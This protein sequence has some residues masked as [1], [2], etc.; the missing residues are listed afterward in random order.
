MAL[1]T[2]M[3]VVVIPGA[4]VVLL[5]VVLSGF[6]ITWMVL[7]VSVDRRVDLDC[8]KFEPQWAGAAA[9]SV[10][11]VTGVP[12]ERAVALAREAV[13]RAGGIDISVHDTWT[14][15]GWTGSAWTNFP[16]R[17]QYQLAI[18]VTSG[19]EGSTEF[20]CCSRPRFRSS[21]VVGRRCLDLARRLEAEVAD[22]ADSG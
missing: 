14:V 5:I 2:A 15:V 12:T 19:P 4:P 6:G 18:A 8:G 11:V 1:F 20:I 10:P 21:L 3:V 7:S 22:L 13:F 9:W 17:Q 16:G